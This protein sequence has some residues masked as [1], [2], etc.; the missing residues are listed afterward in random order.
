MAIIYQS[1]HKFPSAQSACIMVHGL[2]N[3]PDVLMDVADLLESLEI[4]V[5][6]VG[7]TGHN[8]DA[9]CLKD[10][11]EDTWR[12]DVLEAFKMPAK[13]NL[14]CLFV[15]YSLGAALGLDILS[16]HIKFDRMVLLA[17]AIAPRK[18]VQFLGRVAGKFPA[19]PLYSAVPERYRANSYLPLRAYDALHHIYTS[20]KKKRFKHAN[21]P[22][23]VFMDPKDETM[24]M[25][26]LQQ[27]VEDCQLSHWTILTLDSDHVD[28]QT[29]FHHMIM[30]KK[31]MGPK[32]WTDFVRHVKDFIREGAV[33]APKGIS[34][35]V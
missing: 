18:P 23:L 25:E 27:T 19:F 8:Q 11:S 29:M 22:T 3:K 16:D 32:N 5:I 31:T 26:V 35:N 10:I 20:L 24:S 4:P 6:T 14:K 2:N 7:L 15:G 13:R 33:N 9:E 12:N 34:D 28:A 21:V 17:P 1:L 30:N